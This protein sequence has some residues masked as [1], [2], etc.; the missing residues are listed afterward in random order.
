MVLLKKLRLQASPRRK[1][2]VSFLLK[3]C[4]MML[5]IWSIRKNVS[6][7][8]RQSTSMSSG[9]GLKETFT[10]SFARDKCWQFTVHALIKS[11]KRPWWRR[12]VRQ[13]TLN[14][15][16]SLMQCLEIEN[17]HVILSYIL[18]VMIFLTCIDWFPNTF[19]FS[20]MY[21]SN[22]FLLP[23]NF[24]RFVRQT[25]QKTAAPLRMFFGCVFLLFVLRRSGCFV[26]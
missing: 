1:I 23:I 12:R 22:G 9:D 3:Y 14:V 19:A 24:R 18:W 13:L 10:I 4:A 8:R 21:I 25:L 26:T 20:D 17:N 5:P 7:L 2:F 15:T 6:F 11:T 16:F